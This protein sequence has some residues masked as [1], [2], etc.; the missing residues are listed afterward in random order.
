MIGSSGRLPAPR[1]NLI[2][3]GNA[4]IDQ[5]NN[6]AAINFTNGTYRP[7]RFSGGSAGLTTQT[8]TGEASGSSLAGCHRAFKFT[9]GGVG[10]APAAGAYA[11]FNQCIEGLNSA[12]LLWGTAQAKPI[13]ISFRAKASVAG[14]YGLSVRN[15][16]PDRNYIASIALAAGVDTFVALTIPGDTA[17]VWKTDNGI[18][19]R[20]DFDL[21]IGATYSAA[22]GAWGAGNLFGLA[23]GTKLL[24]TTGATL[25]ISNIKIENG[26][27][28]TPYVVD[29]YEV[30]FA[31]CQRY[32]QRQ[33]RGQFQYFADMGRADTTINLLFVH[34]FPVTMRAAPTLVTS[35]A[36]QA[37]TGAAA[38]GITLTGAAGFADGYTYQGAAGGATWAIGQAA[39]HA[40][41]APGGAVIGWDAEL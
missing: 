7:D 18:G 21:G 8:I 24:A 39:Q 26:P 3:N 4:A 5:R 38:A 19:I 37:T 25:E 2:I 13:A 40:P 1:P 6:F 27:T 15:D 16:A 11:Y 32:Y 22:A 41:T 12:A 17:G 35:G 29:D 31:K 9:V 30:A 20:F 33:A 28:Q 23:G 14:N 34:A 10:A 36:F